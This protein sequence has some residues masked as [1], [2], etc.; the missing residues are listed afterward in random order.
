VIDF[1]NTTSNK[2]SRHTSFRFATSRGIEDVTI[3]EAKVAGYSA[4]SAKT[5]IDSVR[6]K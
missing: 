6:T 4:V 5:I 2:T 3:I 1:L